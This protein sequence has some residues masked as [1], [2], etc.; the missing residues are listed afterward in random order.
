MRGRHAR[1]CARIVNCRE[2]KE[3]SP[4][5]LMG[6]LRFTARAILGTPR[7]SVEPEPGAFTIPW[8]ARDQPNSRKLRRFRCCRRVRYT[9]WFRE[10]VFEPIED[11]IE[12][13]SAV[14]DEE[15]NCQR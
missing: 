9:L 14:A 5:Y 2:A 10:G 8:P 6:E 4:R 13:V 11:R 1:Q 15:C 12:N 3:A 7:R